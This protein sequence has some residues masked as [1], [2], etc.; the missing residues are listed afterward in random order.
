MQGAKSKLKGRDSADTPVA[1]GACS[2][3]A[4]LAQLNQIR[5]QHVV[6]ASWP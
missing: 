1:H 5:Q 4:D 6:P 3:P 2:D